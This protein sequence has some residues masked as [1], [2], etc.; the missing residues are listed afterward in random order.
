M[1]R[2][3]RRAVPAEGSEIETKAKLKVAGTAH[4]VVLVLQLLD[5]RIE[6][7]H[8][9]LDLLERG[10]GSSQLV[11]GTCQLKPLGLHF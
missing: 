7:G 6:Q 10:V 5:L 11:V 1:K 4:L 2:G 3:W 9:V 8:L